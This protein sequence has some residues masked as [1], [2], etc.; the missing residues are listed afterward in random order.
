M[1]NF[2]FLVIIYFLLRIFTFIQQNFSYITAF[3]NVDIVKDSSWAMLSLNM[4]MYSKIIKT[5]VHVQNMPSFYTLLIE[6]DFIL[7]RIKH[8]S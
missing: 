6:V 4:L 3:R 8:I 1:Q 7:P 5:F 2:T